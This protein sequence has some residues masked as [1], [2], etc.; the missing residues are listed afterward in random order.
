[1]DAAAGFV[2]VWAGCYEQKAD[3]KM[4]DFWKN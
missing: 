1:V 2:G 4:P 3:L